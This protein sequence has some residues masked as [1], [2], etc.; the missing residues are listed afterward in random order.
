MGQ[1]PSRLL[2]FCQAGHLA[3]MKITI[4]FNNKAKSVLKK[5][6]LLLIVKVTLSSCC[7]DFLKVKTYHIS[8]AAIDEHEMKEINRAYRKKNSVTDVLSFPEFSSRKEIADSGDKDMVLGE[9]VL[10]YNYIADYAKKNGEKVETEVARV[11]SHGLLHLLGFRHGKKMFD[12]QNSVASGI[13]K[14]K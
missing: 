11:V 10:C 4:D 8:F 14:N 12:L 9:I 6:S 7:L 5:A 3:P 13:V 2:F 1:Q